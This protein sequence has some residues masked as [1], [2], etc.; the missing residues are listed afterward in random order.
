MGEQGVVSRMAEDKARG[1]V[2]TIAFFAVAIFVYA[3]LPTAAQRYYGI[4]LGVVT[5]AVG[6][7]A[8][9][10]GHSITFGLPFLPLWAFGALLLA[11]SFYKAF[12][13]WGLFGSVPTAL[14]AIFFAL[15]KLAQAM[16]STETA[17]TIETSEQR[18]SPPGPP[19]PAG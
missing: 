19:D 5:V 17:E 10:R 13:Y 15:V 16:P 4:L 8:S 1:C 9:L 18:P 7:Y 12:G 2:V 14:A 6:V 3:I 11:V